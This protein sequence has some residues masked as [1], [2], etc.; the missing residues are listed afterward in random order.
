MTPTLQVGGQNL[1]IWSEMPKITLLITG[2]A[3][4]AVCHRQPLFSEHTL[5]LPSASCSY[6]LQILPHSFLIMTL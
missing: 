2:R 3:N 4:E 1:D 6:T 5:Y